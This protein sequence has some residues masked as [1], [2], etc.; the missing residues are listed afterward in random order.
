MPRFFTSDIAGDT[1]RI[2]GADAHHIGRVLR[3][4]I[5]E[6][7]TVCDTR[8]WDYTGP[9]SSITPQEVTVTI[10]RR[11][12]TT[13]EPTLSVTLYQGL[14]KSDKLE[15]IIQKAVEL[16]VTRVVPVVT[17]RSIA[18]A[19]ADKAD[20]KR[21]RWQRIAAEAA[22]QSGRG[23]IPAVE[24]PLSWKHMIKELSPSQT[25]VFYE[26]GGKP[27]SER[28]DP[29]HTQLAILIGPEGGFSPEEID[30]LT[31]MGVTPATLGKRILRCETA[32]IAALSAIMTLS[33]NME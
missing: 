12:P 17:A 16:G 10:E 23:I 30:E 4:R 25:L 9:I 27:L 31:A 22:G 33:G 15:W 2:T 29:S 26:G 24:A 19:D 28:I 20:K 18:K 7:L 8:G 6:E 32:P 1:A 11:Q 21:E 5:G 3:M 14:P 13:S